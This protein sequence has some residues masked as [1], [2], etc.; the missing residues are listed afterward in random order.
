V[1][2][3]YLAS[4]DLRHGCGLQAKKRVFGNTPDVGYRVGLAR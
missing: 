1:L 2:L 4:A 3:L